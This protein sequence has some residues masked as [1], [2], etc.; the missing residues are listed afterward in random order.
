MPGCLLRPCCA[1]SWRSMLDTAAGGRQPQGLVYCPNAVDATLGARLQAWLRQE[2]TELG[3]GRGQ[4]L[5]HTAAAAVIPW[6]R[7][8]EG[9]RVAQWGW[10][11]DYSKHCVDPQA[12]AAVPVPLRELCRRGL[13]T[14]VACATAA[15]APAALPGWL[16]RPGADEHFSQCIVNEY[17]PGDGIP[18][19]LDDPVGFGEAVL[20]ASFGARRTLALRPVARGRA[21]VAGL[22]GGEEEVVHLDLHPGSVYLLVG[23]ARWQWQHCL[24]GGEE[25]LRYSVT[26]RSPPTQQHV[27]HG[28][29][30]AP[31]HSDV[32]HV[33][34]RHRM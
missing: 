1:C 15:A 2:G 17:L 33:L 13:G 22:G 4:V 12:V 30:A 8:V 7:A 9:R 20:V 26:F 18:W 29:P 27:L 10:R 5:D 3:E 34:A 14:L 23:E 25:G 31:A 11:Y 16:L 32:H 6:E 21:S 19:H 24:R 28:H